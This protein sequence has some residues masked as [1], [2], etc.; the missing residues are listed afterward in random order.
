MSNLW[1]QRFD[2]VKGKAGAR[3]MK[4]KYTNGQKKEEQWEGKKGRRKIVTERILHSSEH[5]YR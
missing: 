5:I 1:K 3:E 4:P 2:I